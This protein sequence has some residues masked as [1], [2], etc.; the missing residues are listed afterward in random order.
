MYIFA[1]EQRNEDHIAEHSVT[2]EEA[3]S[4]VQAA[5]RPF[6]IRRN[7]QKRLVRGP[8]PA[9]RWLQVI[10]VLRD[11]ATIDLSWIAPADRLSIDAVKEVVYVI[12]AR[13]LTDS[14][15]FDSRKKRGSR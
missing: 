4:V 14:E 7:D 10:Y 1:W 8:T 6:P 11:A 9:G 3:E 15:R 2:C 5:R 12:H 13:E